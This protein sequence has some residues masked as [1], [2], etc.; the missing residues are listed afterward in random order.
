MPK[1]KKNVI[2]K[3]KTTHALPV[4][5]LVRLQIYAAANNKDQQDIVAELLDQYLPPNPFKGTRNAV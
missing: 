2:L 5:V 1:Q 4:D 3:K